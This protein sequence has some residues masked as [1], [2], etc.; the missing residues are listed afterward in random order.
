MGS[1][2]ASNSRVGRVAVVGL[3]NV[4]RLIADM[5]IERGFEVRGVEAGQSGR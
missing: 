2:S 1:P 4:G 3:G 5:L